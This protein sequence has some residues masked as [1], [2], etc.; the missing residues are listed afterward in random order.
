[1]ASSRDDFIIAIRSAFLKKS[2]QQKFSLLTL[3]FLSIFVIVLSNL[4]LKAVRLLKTGINEVVYRSS[5]IVSIPEN[6][7]KNSYFNILEY[8]TFYRNYKKNETEL[9]ELKSQKVSNEIIQYENK[10]LKN[11]INDYV[12][13]SDKILAKIIVDHDSPFL[14][15]V[16]INKGSNSKIKIGTNIYDQSYLVG[17][18][19]EVNYNTSRVLLLSDLNSNVPVTIAPQNI[20]AIM[21]GGGKDNG[22]IKYIKDG[23]FGKF[24]ENSIIYT[25]GTGGIF[26]SG[27]PI[28]KLEQNSNKL[29]INFFSDFSQLKYVFAE[30]EVKTENPNLLQKS[31]DKSDENNYPINTKIQIL[32]DEKKII[33][34]SN[35]KFKE[36]NENLKLEINYLNTQI[37]SYQNELTLQKNKINQSIIDKEELEF[38][39]LNLLY[40]HKCQTRKLFSTGYKVGTPEYKQ[41]ILNKGKISD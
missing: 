18:V 7:L 29:G 8:S 1:M 25:S 33:E 21:I 12:S 9:N 23:I 11:L 16:I 15:S 24:D 34:D 39:R 26:K 5:F 19:V 4:N 35:L 27:I 3:I 32:E 40:S 14:K 36:E 13:S 6:F 41:C 22:E 17:R 2:T 38:L 28:G 10:E 20:Q 30:V 31:N 37:S